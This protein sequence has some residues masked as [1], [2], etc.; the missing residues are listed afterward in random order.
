MKGHKWFAHTYDFMNRVTGTETRFM[1][2]HRPMIVGEAEGRVLEVGAG[3]GASFPYYKKAATVIATEPYPYMLQKA[4]ERLSELGL[5]NIEARQA[6]AEEMPFEDAAFD[7]VVSTLVFCSVSDPS[8]AMKEVRR[9]LKP[10][11]TF[12]FV[13]HV[14]DDESWRGRLQDFIVPLWG[15]IGAGC[16]PNRRTL[17]TMKEAGFE[18]T[19]LARHKMGGFPVIVGLARPNDAGSASANG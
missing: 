3:T 7:T 14:R 1:T 2:K 6:A 16:H 13:E 4:Q 11:G 5:P 10:G 17:E 8:R 19:D 9:V 15:W 18:V 12:R